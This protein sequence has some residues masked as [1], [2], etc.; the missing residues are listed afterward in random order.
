MS[1]RSLTHILTYSRFFEKWFRYTSETTTTVFISNHPKA[2]KHYGQAIDLLE[3]ALLFC[4]DEISTARLIAHSEF[5]KQADPLIKAHTAYVDRD[6][7]SF[8]VKLFRQSLLDVVEESDLENKIRLISDLGKIFDAV[9]LIIAEVY[10]IDG[11]GQLKNKLYELV[12]AKAEGGTASLPKSVFGRLTQ[13]EHIV[14]EL[15]TSGFSTKKI[16]NKL[17]V[18]E[19]TIQTHRKNIRRKL[20]LTG[21]QNLYSYL[22]Y[23]ETAL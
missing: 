22:K 4:G 23:S 13:A 10:Y 6:V 2:L 20:S 5:R 18:T 7:F 12:N 11:M 19:S 16:A 17:N 1:E 8:S 14:C 21:K 9:D 15:I 3:Q